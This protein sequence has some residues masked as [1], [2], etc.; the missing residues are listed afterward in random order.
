MSQKMSKAE[1]LAAGKSQGYI[2]TNSKCYFFFF[3]A[4]AFLG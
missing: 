2:L 1:F 3:C 4:E